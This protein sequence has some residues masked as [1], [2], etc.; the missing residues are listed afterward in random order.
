[1]SAMIASH[2]GLKTLEEVDPEMY[3]LIE[4]EK[5]RQFTSIARQTRAVKNSM[6][7]LIFMR[8]SVEHGFGVVFMKR[9]ARAPYHRN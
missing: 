8:V 6:R 2:P 7:Y 9:D 5:Q 4:L 1:M 3:E